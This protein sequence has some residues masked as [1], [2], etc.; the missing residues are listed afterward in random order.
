MSNFV[1]D[2]FWYADYRDASDLA[3]IVAGDM[4]E[5]KIDVRDYLKFQDNLDTLTVVRY[6][7]LMGAELSDL[8]GMNPRQ[9]QE[10][11]ETLLHKI[12][13]FYDGTDHKRNYLLQLIQYPFARW[14]PECLWVEHCSVDL[15]GMTDIK[16]MSVKLSNA[17]GFKYFTNSYNLAMPVFKIQQP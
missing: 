1:Y 12:F 15:K 17:L 14:G 4:C 9:I 5:K 16:E 13:D 2:E 3:V 7:L 8:E 6:C 10:Y 11:S